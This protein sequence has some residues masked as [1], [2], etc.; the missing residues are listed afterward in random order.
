MKGA[1]QLVLPPTRAPAAWTPAPPAAPPGERSAAPLGERSA[2]PQGERSAAPLGERWAGILLTES[3]NLAQRQ[4]SLIDRLREED[5]RLVLQHARQ[6]TLNRNELLFAQGDPHDGIVIVNA[7]RIRSFYTAPSGR[8]ITLAYW[9]PGNFIGG[10]NIFGGGTHMWAAVAVQKS[11]VTMLPGKA[12]RDLA[13]TIPD[14]ALG[15]ID[16]LAFKAKCYSAVAQML[17][18]RSIA[19]RLVQLLLFL[20][21]TYG[22]EERDGIVIAASFTH[23]ELAHLIGATRQWVTASLARLRKAGVL[24]YRR[25]ILQIREPERLLAFYNGTE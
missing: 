7:G 15:I 11:D 10:P 16:A 3:E 2:A 18:T 5:R 20:A 17:G 14:L 8:E 21:S 25:G 19:E 12:L 9:F 6:W 23:N 24:R 1:N 22:I 13:S 4:P